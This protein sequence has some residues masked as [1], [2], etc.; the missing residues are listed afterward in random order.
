MDDSTAAKQLEERIA[1]DSVIAPGD[2]ELWEPSTLLVQ[3]VEEVSQKENQ[4]EK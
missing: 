4:S 2:V 1:S 3:F